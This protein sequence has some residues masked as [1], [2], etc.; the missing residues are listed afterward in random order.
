MYILYLYIR[1]VFKNSCHLGK[2]KFMIKHKEL[3]ALKCVIRLL[4]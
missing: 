3:N 2:S 4:N 1:N